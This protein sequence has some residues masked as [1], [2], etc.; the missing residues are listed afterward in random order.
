MK[1]FRSLESAQE[2][3]VAL[4]YAS[5]NSYASFVLY[6]LPVC[7][8][9]AHWRMNQL[10]IIINYY[11]SHCCI[12][13]ISLIISCKSVSTGTCLMATTWPVSLCIA[14]NTEPYELAQKRRIS[15][16]IKY[17]G[18]SLNDGVYVIAATTVML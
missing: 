16:K 1:H 4:G 8:M 17:N 7:L 14:L 13:L 5:S 12:I 2:A 3:K 18:K 6:K 11:L 15:D 10:L 9:N